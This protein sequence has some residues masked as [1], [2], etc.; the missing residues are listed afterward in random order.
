MKSLSVPFQFPAENLRVNANVRGGE[1][2]V[3]VLGEVGTLLATSD[4]TTG[5]LLDGT[6]SW[7]GEALAGL[8]GKT[9]SL[10]FRLRGGSL[11][12]YWLTD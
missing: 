7:Q 2:Q 3:E 6:V 11:Y 1:L 10:R 8:A 12:S 9:V 4:T 5:D